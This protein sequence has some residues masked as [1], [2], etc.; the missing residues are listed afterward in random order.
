MSFLFEAFAWLISFFYQLTRSYGMAIV[1]LTVAVRLVLFPLTAKQAKSMQ[2][3][4]RVQP[5]LKRLQTKYKNDRQKLNEEM[6]KFYKENNINPLA[7]CLPLL[8]Q[9]PLFFILYRVIEGLSHTKNGG[10]VGAPKY[11]DKSSELYHAL[12]KAGGTMVSWGI[13]L[14]RSASS[15]SK[16]GFGTALP[17][18]VL[19]AIVIATGYYQQRQM[20]ARNPQAAQNPQAQMMGKIFPLMF[21]LISYS[22]QAGVVVYFAVSNLW[23]IGQQ[24]LIFRDPAMAAGPAPSSGSGSGGDDVIDAPSKPKAKAPAKPRQPGKNR[25]TPKQD[26]RPRKKGGK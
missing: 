14:S 20:T 7:G 16:D 26:G 10:T 15:A 23:Q 12:E 18:F 19:V 4:Q 21:G 1:L 13:D 5:E 24:Y 25:P 6:M 11:I 2:S 17:Y 8:L 22:I 9:M 3:M